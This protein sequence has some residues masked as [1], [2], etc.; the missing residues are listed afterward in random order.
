MPLQKSF[1][2]PSTNQQPSNSYFKGQVE[3]YDFISDGHAATLGFIGAG[4]NGTFPADDGGEEITLLSELGIHDRGELSIEVLGDDGAVE[5]AHKLIHEGDTASIPGGKQMRISTTRAVVEYVCEYPG[6]PVDTESRVQLNSNN[7]RAAIRNEETR[8]ATVA[9]L[10]ELARSQPKIPVDDPRTTATDRADRRHKP[11]RNNLD[12]C[13]RAM[14]GAHEGTNTAWLE[15]K[16][17][18][19]QDNAGIDLL[20]F[21]D[22]YPELCDRVIA[23]ID[24]S[25]PYRTLYEASMELLELS[26]GAEFQE[27]NGA[28]AHPLGVEAIGIYYWDRIN[29]LLEEAYA[30]LAT[31]SPNASK[32]G[33]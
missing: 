24:A 1:D 28:T 14:K 7:V 26:C 11:Y 22:K 27:I 20:D 19:A 16:L 18:Q 25:E 33:G 21:Y 4:F 3:S 32:L 15:M 31:L 23:A 9:Q 10:T 30:V 2:F 13:F 17:E 6:K 12:T 29:P 5:A 8:A